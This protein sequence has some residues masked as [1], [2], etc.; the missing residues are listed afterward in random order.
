MW[1]AFWVSTRSNLCRKSRQEPP[2]GAKDR[3]KAAQEAAQE[4]L[5][6]Q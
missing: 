1:D 3:S 4:A 6:Q 5:A 2:K